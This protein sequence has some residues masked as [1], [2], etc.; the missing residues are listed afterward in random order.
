MIKLKS[1]NPK[2]IAR[3]VREFDLRAL[4]IKRYIL[5]GPDVGRL[6]FQR[7]FFD[8]KSD[9]WSLAGIT[10]TTSS[11]A[12]M[13]AITGLLTSPVQPWDAIICTSRAVKTNVETVLQAQVDFLQDRLGITKII[14]PK[15]PIIPLGV[16]TEDFA[17]TAD[18]K[19]N[20]RNALGITEDIV[21][22]YVGRLAFHESASLCYVQ[23]SAGCR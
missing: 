8:L 6:A 3:H 15:L 4:K 14:L 17:F 9:S 10:H 13:D 1:V 19:A 23:R 11:S 12:A 2:G 16:N 7:S 21:V 5:P 18:Q 20:A 22:L